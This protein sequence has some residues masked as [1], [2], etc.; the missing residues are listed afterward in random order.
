MASKCQCQYL[1][2]G[3]KRFFPPPTTACRFPPCFCAETWGLGLGVLLFFFR[4]GGFFLE[5]VVG[6]CEMMVKVVF[7]FRE[8]LMK[9]Q[10]DVQAK[11]EAV[12]HQLVDM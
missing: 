11:N 6:S 9:I 5:G 8:V 3:S 2:F 10:R 7:F 4:G 12:H 1:G